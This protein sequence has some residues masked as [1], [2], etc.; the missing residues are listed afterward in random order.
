[1][2]N[3][4]EPRAKVGTEL[5]TMLVCNRPDEGVLDEVVCPG[6]VAG[7]RTGIAPQPED[8][9]FEQSTEIV[10]LSRLCS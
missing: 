8:F 7:Q 6:L 9:S 10:N 1:M 2:H 5:P 3:G 4:E